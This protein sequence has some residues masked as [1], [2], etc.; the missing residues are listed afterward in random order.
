MPFRIPGPTPHLAYGK[1][2]SFQE[3]LALITGLFLNNMRK[4]NQYLVAFCVIWGLLGTLM[5]LADSFPQPILE[6]TP[7][8]VVIV[9]EEGRCYYLMAYYSH[10]VLPRLDSGKPTFTWVSGVP[11]STEIETSPLSLRT[12]STS[13]NREKTNGLGILKFVTKRTG[14]LS[15]KYQLPP[16]SYLGVEESD[17]SFLALLLATSL[18]A[19]GLAVV[20]MKWLN[21]LKRQPCKKMNL[22]RQP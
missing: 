7:G 20:I 12:E 13:G 4:I 16:D 6:T 17:D 2:N 14:K 9:A 21:E 1:K 22:T 18:A 10:G 3:I 5:F 15:I 11:A 8:E 19:L